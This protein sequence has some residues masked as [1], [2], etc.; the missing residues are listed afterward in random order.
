ML[1]LMGQTDPDG[2]RIQLIAEAA[3]ISLIAVTII[4]VLIGVCLSFHQCTST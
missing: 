3:L 2:C 1:A 4:L